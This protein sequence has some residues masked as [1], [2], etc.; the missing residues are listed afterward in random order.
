MI[1]TTP[2]PTSSNITERSPL[3]DQLARKIDTNRDGQLTSGE[4]SEFLAGLMQSLD[5]E[6][7]SASPGTSEP[8][9]AG[10]LNTPQPAMTPA[11]ASALLR[12]AFE[13]VTRT[14]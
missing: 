8:A 13:H 1:F 3:L 4:F 12:K 7:R 2:L 10:L 9:S 5:D 14:R 6:Q 11:Q